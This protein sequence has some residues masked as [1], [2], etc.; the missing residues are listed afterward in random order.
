MNFPKLQQ[1]TWAVESDDLLADDENPFSTNK[2]T[3]HSLNYPIA[4]TCTPTKVCVKTCYFGCGPSTWSASLKKQWRLYNSTVADPKRVAAVVARW[5]TR[6][7]LS[8]VR[9]NGGGDLFA[10]SVECI[11]AAAPL[12][13]DIPQ[14]VVTRLPQHAVNIAPADNVFVHFSLDRHSW[15]RA[16]AMRQYR[17]NWFWSYQCDADEMPEKSL[18]P[19]VF[20]DHYDP[21]GAALNADDCPLNARADIA[22]TCRQCRRCFDGTAVSRGKELLPVLNSRID[23]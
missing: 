22:D 4:L 1:K 20:Y 15:V 10:E 7:R 23:A 6:L 3:G 9:W 21:A 5:A 19:V 14:W 13:P 12:M 16:A 18:A 8:F 17:G 11:N 2:V